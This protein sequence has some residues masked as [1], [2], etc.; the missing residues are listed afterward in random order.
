MRV[1]CTGSGEGKR[2]KL[3]PVDILS[4]LSG[5]DIAHAVTEAQSQ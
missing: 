4:S 1:Y 2:G 3:V 5:S